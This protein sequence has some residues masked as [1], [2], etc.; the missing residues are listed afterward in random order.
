MTYICE[1]RPT[2]ETH[3]PV[4]VRG[5]IYI[6]IYK[7]QW[8]SFVGEVGLFCRN[9][10]PLTRFRTRRYLPRVYAACQL[11]NQDLHLWKVIY[12]CGKRPTNPLSRSWTQCGVSLCDAHVCGCSALKS[13]VLVWKET[14]KLTDSF[15][16][17][18]SAE[19]RYVT[20]MY[21]AEALCWQD[22]CEEVCFS[23]SYSYICIILGV[24]SS[25]CTRM[26]A[27]VNVCVNVCLYECTS[28]APCTHSVFNRFFF[29]S[30]TGGGNAR[31]FIC[32]CLTAEKKCLTS[33]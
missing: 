23:C 1:R 6:Y 22:R 10:D 18:R 24:K 4:S 13:D 2:K 8:V 29:P 33:L 27:Y 26:R 14:Y 21:A 30:H 17:E 25:L 31:H 28:R 9:R 7:G 11:V 19:Y 15:V 16:T 32:K 20:R 3:W 5:G 12:L